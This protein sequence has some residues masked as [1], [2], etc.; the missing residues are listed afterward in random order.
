MGFDIPDEADPEDGITLTYEEFLEGVKRMKEVDSP[1][2]RDPADAWPDFVGWRVNYERAAY[3]VA[4]AVDP[5]RAKWSGPRRDGRRRSSR[6][7]PPPDGSRAVTA[8][9]RT[10]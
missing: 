3:L 7:V 4:Y 10:A 6:C 8:M 2:E 1:L 5:V 9:A